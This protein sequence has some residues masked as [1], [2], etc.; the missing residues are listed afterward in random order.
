[1]LQPQEFTNVGSWSP[2]LEVAVTLGSHMSRNTD[3]STTVSDTR[4]ESCNVA[5]F[6]TTSET[7]III[8]SVDG[9]VFVVPLAQLF[10]GR[11]DV[12]HA[13]RFPHSLCTVVG[14]AASAIPVALEWFRVEGNL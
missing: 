5:G 3:G 10:D 8:L 2:V 4:A 11:F 14:V 7:E 6:M 1:M 12:F 13:S 9:D